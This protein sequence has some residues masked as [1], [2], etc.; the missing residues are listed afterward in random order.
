MSRR[1]VACPTPKDH[2]TGGKRLTNASMRQKGIRYHQTHNE[3]YKCYRRYLVVILGHEDMGNREFRPPGG[4]PRVMLTKK[5]RFGTSM[6][7][8]KEGG[9]WQPALHHGGTVISN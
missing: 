6:R 3:A 2:C 4:G 9:R 8:G 5:S 7:L 1:I